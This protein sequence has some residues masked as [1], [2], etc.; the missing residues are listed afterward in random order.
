MNNKE[1]VLNVILTFYEPYA[2]AEIPTHYLTPKGQENRRMYHCIATLLDMLEKDQQTDDQALL[3]AF[4][5]KLE[6]LR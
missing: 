6:G 1:R 5:Q 4:A 2:K 3:T